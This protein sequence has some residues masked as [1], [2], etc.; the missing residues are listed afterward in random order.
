M[1]KLADKVELQ[2]KQIKAI[3]RALV[4]AEVIE[5]RDIP[6]EASPTKPKDAPL[7]LGFWAS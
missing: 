2:E 5:A 4:D 7:A 6:A 1:Q 3:A